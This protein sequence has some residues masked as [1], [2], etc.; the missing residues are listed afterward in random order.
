MRRAAASTPM[1]PPSHKPLPPPLRAALLAMQA[2]D[3]A[4][5]D[6][7]AA[8]GSLYE[9]YHP[10]MAALHQ[11]HAQALGRLI[12]AHGWPNDK[13]AGPDG[14]EAAWLVAQHAIADPAFMRR[15]LALV[16]KE[17]AAGR[18]PMWQHAYLHDR[19]QVSAG[20]PQRYGTQFELTPSGPV[21]CEVEDPTQLEERRRAVGLGPS[22]ERL[23]A[24]AQAPRPSPEAYLAQQA[25]ERAWRREVGWAEGSEA[26]AARRMA[27]PDAGGHLPPAGT[28]PS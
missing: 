23:A 6:E 12:D 13:R 26:D 7:L 2:H 27:G 14:A 28:D 8:D 22:H 24:L 19:V 5:R 4:L 17:A 25:A 3:L 21:A 15:C 10:R 1:P 18:V 9:G 16:A 11:A 20:R